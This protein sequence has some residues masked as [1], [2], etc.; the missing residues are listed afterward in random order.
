MTRSSRRGPKGRAWGETYVRP[1]PPK[2]SAPPHSAARRLSDY[3]R[4]EA[5]LLSG[6][7]PPAWVAWPARL[8]VR[9]FTWASA[10]LPVQGGYLPVPACAGDDLD[11]C[12][13]FFVLIHRPPHGGTGE[14]LWNTPT[15][16]FAELSLDLLFP[17]LHGEPHGITPLQSSP[18]EDPLRTPVDR[19]GPIPNRASVPAGPATRETL[20][21]CRRA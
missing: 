16:R 6:R 18:V 14:L 5:C 20:R 4:D 15:S 7:R 3:A 12:G 8:K 17:A 13:C 10:R 21:C 1:K 11:I 19:G 2:Q 9:I